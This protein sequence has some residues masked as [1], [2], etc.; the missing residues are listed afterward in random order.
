MGNKNVQHLSHIDRELF[1]KKSHYPVVYAPEI[2]SAS[3]PPIAMMSGLVDQVRT[4][5]KALKDYTLFE[6]VASWR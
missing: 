5:F 2:F 6:I 3:L 1:P 4:S